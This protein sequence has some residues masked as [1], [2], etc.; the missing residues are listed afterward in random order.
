MEYTLAKLLTVNAV[1]AALITGFLIAAKRLKFGRR[2]EI[3]VGAFGL[4]GW[5]YMQWWF[6]NRPDFDPS[7]HYPLHVCDF[8]S[9]LVVLAMIWP[10]R[11]LRSLIY[12]LAPSAL[13]AFILPTGTAD[14]GDLAF[15]LFWA[16]HIAIIGMFPYE[17]WVRGFRPAKRDY[18][19][20]VG[21]ATI[22]FIIMFVLGWQMEWNYAYV[23]KKGPP[24][25]MGGW[26]WHAPIMF[27][28]VNVAFYLL[29]IAGRQ[30]HAG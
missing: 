24:F 8:S 25:H 15:W 1:S 30:K 10:A 17:V 23:G 9:G 12:F 27:A 18:L 4:L 7:N 13:L 20:A 21:F 22:Y 29:Y 28:L 16:G 6:W 5:L 26:P 11:A 3:A 2:I 19:F 14:L